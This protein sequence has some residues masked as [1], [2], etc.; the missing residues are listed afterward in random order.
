M[1]KQLKQLKKLSEIKSMKDIVPLSKAVYPGTH[2][3]LFG[4]TLI[5]KNFN[6]SAVIILGTQECSYYSKTMI[7][8]NTDFYNRCFSVITNQSDITFGSGQ[9][10]EQA[11]DELLDTENPKSIFIVTTCVIE[12]TGDDIDSI[13]KNLTDKYKLPI[14]VVHTEHFRCDTHMSGMTN[15]LAETVKIMEDMPK[16]RCVNILGHRHNMFEESELC[17]VLKE[18]DIPINLN[19]PAV[20][21][22]KSIQ[23][24]S[25]AMLNIVCDDIGISLA[26]KM[27][28]RFGIEYVILNRSC[29]INIIEDVYIK[30]F[31]IFGIEVPERIKKIKGD[32]INEL[33]K[34]KSKL[35]N[36]T[37]IYGNTPIN[38]L[39]IVHFFTDMGMI[40]KLVQIKEIKE[41]DMQTIEQI[42]NKGVN[43]VVAKSANIAPL[44]DLYDELKPNFYI[45]HENPVKLAKKGIIQLALDNAGEKIGF[46][47]P[48]FI[49]QTIANRYNMEKEKI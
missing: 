6:D 26:I 25:K 45:G 41:S 42:I 39:D 3:P 8:S 9:K 2:C 21:D 32:T 40:P 13:A 22:T 20:C 1:L 4:A 7:I 47:L 23:N 14:M 10:V 27:K 17:T 29:D 24:A 16:E 31:N 33:E 35:K 48:L 18:N 37:Y 19:L 28:E 34:L 12:V 43:P 49:A 15:V 46:E 44:Q 36:I 38:T 5:L 11:I 30:I